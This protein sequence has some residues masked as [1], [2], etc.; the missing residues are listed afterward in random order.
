[1]S[2][3]AIEILERIR[4]DRFY[5]AG[6]LATMTGLSEQ[7]CRAA[8]SRLVVSGHL[9]SSLIPTSPPITEYRHPKTPEYG[10]LPAGP[11]GGG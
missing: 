11:G 6:D 7:K 1:M 8:L 5:T 9:K 3:E 2:I 10:T 4:P